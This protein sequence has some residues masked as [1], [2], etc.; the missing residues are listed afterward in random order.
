MILSGYK[1]VSKYKPAG[2]QPKAIKELIRGV[3]NGERFQVLKGVTGSGKTFTIANVIA[4]FD[5]PVLV[6]SHNKT[7]ASQLYSELKGFFPENNVEYFVSYFDYYR[8]EAYIPSSDSYIEKNSQRNKEIE[9]MRMSTYNSVLTTK[10]TIVVASVSSI[11][12]ALDPSE[13]REQIFYIEVGQKWKRN[14]FLRELVQKNYKRNE[15]DLILGS[16]SSKGDVVFIRPAH[17][18][19][20]VIRVVFWGDEIE[21]INTCH[22][23]TK[24]VFEQFKRYRIFPGEAYTVSNDL[25]RQVVEKIEIELEE[26]I[27]YFAKNNKLLEAQRIEERTRKDIDSLSEFGTCPGIEN[28][29]RYFDRREADERPYT[30]LDYLKDQNPLLIIDESHMMLPQLRGMYNGDRSRKQTLVDYGFRLPSALDN[31]PLRFEEFESSFDFQTIYISATPEEYELDKTHGVLTRLYVRPTGLLDPIIEVRPSENQVEDIYDEI[32]KQKLKNERT[33]ILT[34]TKRLTE[35]LTRHYLAKNEKIAFLHSEHNTFDR[36]RI[37]LKLRKGVYDTVI[38]VNLLREG[39]D[40]PEVSLIVVLDAD[41][42]GFLRD[43]KSLIQIA[44][45]AARNANGRVLM[46]AEKVSRSME[47]AIADNQEKRALQVEY[48]RVHNIVPKTIVKDIA[49][50]L[51]DD[52]KDEQ[53]SF[54]LND[55]KAKAKDIKAKALLLEELRAK[56]NEAAQNLDYEKAIEIRD[57]IIELEKQ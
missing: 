1:L 11:Y 41:K 25:T 18:E 52:A 48:N 10:N 37:L 45:R 31:R 22:P 33:L 57:L 3:E 15:T 19:E 28:Y 55:N 56:M 36:N 34:T 42:E 30:L 54:F 24:A 53:I 21:T 13:Y 5:R 49:D 27:K 7:L 46:Y 35:E 29:S 51:L 38:G 23:V 14:D 39:I 4:H 40:L 32:Q 50:S 8:P 20:F 43:T 16:F 12:G 2:D 44:G 17:T 6:L 26:R 47:E 9:A